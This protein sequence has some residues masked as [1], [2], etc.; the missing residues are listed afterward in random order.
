MGFHTCYHFQIT[1]TYIFYNH[2]SKKFMPHNKNCSIFDC[3]LNDKKINTLKF[4]EILNFI[5]NN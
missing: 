3:K 2:S 4:E 1:K 5:E